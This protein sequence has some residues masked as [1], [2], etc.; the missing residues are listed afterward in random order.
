MYQLLVF[1]VALVSACLASADEST[2]DHYVVRLSD[3]LRAMTVRACFAHVPTVLRAGDDAAAR[4]LRDARWLG[5]PSMTKA[6]R[7]RLTLEAPKGKPC[8]VYTVD[9][10]QAADERA[11]RRSG[12]AGGDL[13]ITPE[14]WLWRPAGAF[15]LRFDLPDL[16]SPSVPWPQ[17]EPSDHPWHYRI[18]DAP[19]TWAA[20]TAFGRLARDTL[21]FPG[22]SIEVAIAD[23]AN[24]ANIASIT[25]WLR[26]T[27]GAMTTVYGSFPL[28]RVQVLVIPGDHTSPVPWGQV[29]RGGAPAVHFYIDRNAGLDEL[30]EDWTAFHEFSHLFLPF[31]QRYDAYLSEGFASY[32]QNITRARSG[33]LTEAEAWANLLRGFERGR[34]AGGRET[35]ATAARRMG[36]DRNYMRV[37]WSGAAIALESDVALRTAH[38]GRDGLGALLGELN[39]C[40]RT[41]NE[42][43][44][45]VELS[46][47]LD[48]L[49]AQTTFS[50][51]NTVLAA[52]RE[53]P[54]IFPL[55]IKLGVTLDNG[56]VVLNDDAP[57]ARVRRAI[58][59]RAQVKA[60][61]R[62][63][64]Q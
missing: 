38:P 46:A 22:G 20:Q 62:A 12:F 36:R 19:R 34:N 61:G 27:A 7:D 44:T 40:C 42:A 5:G 35:L 16:V 52:S 60:S 9:V 15:T 31:I 18:T 4:Y 26:K 57:L 24:V 6:S 23:A 39:A 8:L 13:I 58:T 1:F 10:G 63:A 29:L 47:T 49:S 30:L 14:I 41:D 54:D 43:W 37:Y 53:F 50:D 28:A 3:D 21:A 17:V 59:R 32:F 64:S 55:L 25:D 56:E 45:G 33:N 51:L 2:T 11:L 48:R